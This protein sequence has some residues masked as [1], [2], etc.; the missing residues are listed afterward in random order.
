MRPTAPICLGVKQLE[1]AMHLVAFETENGDTVFVNPDQVRF[2]RSIG[3]G[4]TI[5]FGPDCHVPVAV[6]PEEVL[7]VLQANTAQRP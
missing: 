7:R 6:R 1:E 3:I 5:E 4:S 2:V